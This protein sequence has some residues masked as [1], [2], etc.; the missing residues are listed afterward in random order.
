[1]A[2]MDFDPAAQNLDQVD[3]D[4]VLEYRLIIRLEAIEDFT[5][6]WNDGLELRVAA[7]LARSER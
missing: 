7:H 2:G 1:M 4:F 5:P 3:D 6:H